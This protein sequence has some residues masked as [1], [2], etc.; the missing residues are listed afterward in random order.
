MGYY[1]GRGKKE[2]NTMQEGIV[3]Q[4]NQLNTHFYQIVASDFDESRQYF[5]SGWDSC[6]PELHKLVSETGGKLQVLDLGCG[7]GR[8]G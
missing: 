8:F 6:L 2:I 5:W 3:T 1:T 4:L 7:N